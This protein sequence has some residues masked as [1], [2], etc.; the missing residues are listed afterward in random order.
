[1]SKKPNILFIIADQH[2]YDC[3]N[4]S[5]RNK[6]GIKTPNIDR[7]AE[8]GMW[9]NNAYTTSPVCCPARQSLICGRRPE[10]FGAL[11]NYNIT[12]PVMNLRPD[13][14]SYAQLLKEN[15]YNNSFVGVWDISPIHKP[16]DYGFD[17][18][19]K[20]ERKHTANTIWGQT[21]DIPFE[22]SDPY[23]LGIKVC[24][25]IDRLS[26]DD[27]PWHISLNFAEPH[28]A[29]AP[30]REFADLYDAD[31]L[32]PWDGFGDKFDNKP[33]IQAQQLVNWGIENKGWKD[34]W[35]PIVAKYHAIITQ[36]DSIVGI[37]MNK[38][39]ETGNYDNT[40]VVYTSDHGDMCGS[41]GMFDKHYIMYEDVIHVPFIVRWPE[42][43]RMGQK[44]DAYSVHFLDLVPTIL[45]I[46]DIQKPDNVT[47]HGESLKQILFN[48]EIPENWRNEAVSSYHGQQ[49]GLFCQRSVKTD[50]YKYVWNPTDVDELYDL[51]N[52]PGE[53]NNLINT[54]DYA[55][56]ADLRKRLYDTLVRDNDFLIMRNN[57]SW[58]A[59]QLLEGRKRF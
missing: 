53:L 7:I 27:K 30:V 36:I 44:T 51:V 13:D 47:L 55:V 12:L 14:F 56:L 49:F 11:W 33:Y 24:D 4:Y 57:H 48:N 32:I 23:R 42:K 22:E 35:A 58:V 52:D 1:M 16:C 41:H 37:V 8:E 34:Y 38:L 45:D 26:K 59:P 18:F 15:G 43:I 5:G 3:V 54:I 20:N 25:E 29:Y 40:I 9:F 2:R 19:I 46:C 17:N 28:P 39:K 50:R 6:N 21:L 10:T 31:K